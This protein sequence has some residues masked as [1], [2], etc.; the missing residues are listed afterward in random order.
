MASRVRQSL[1]EFEQRFHEEIA[2]ERAENR[3]LYRRASQRL[4]SRRVERTHRHGTVRFALLVLLLVATAVIVTVAM[5]ET[6]Y[7]VMG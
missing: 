4:R 7:I 5:F 1:R 6:I 3:H 2:D